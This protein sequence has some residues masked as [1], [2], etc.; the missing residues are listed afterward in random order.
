MR[1]HWKRFLLMFGLS[2]LAAAAMVTVSLGRYA[3]EDFSL[4]DLTPIYF[5]LAIF[6][7]PLTAFVALPALLLLRPRLRSMRSVMLYPLASAL[8]V[9]SVSAAASW[10]GAFV[11]ESMTVGEAVLF[12]GAFAV[13]G[14]TFGLAFIRLNGEAWARRRVTTFAYF[15]IAVCATA[16]TT[17]IL[18]FVE[19]ALLASADNG[20]V[21][22]AVTMSE[23]RSGHT[24]TLLPDGRVLLIGG[25]I[26]VRGDEVST[27]S[28]EIYDPRT[29]ATR[30]SGKLLTPRAG[31]TATL[32]PDGDVLVT[33]GGADQ[34]AL[35]GAELYRAKTG[36]FV[37]VG[38]MSAPRERHSATL[39][40]DGRVL[41]TGGTV[42]QPSDAAD[43]Y[44]PRTRTFTP[45]A[46]MRSR[47]A[48]HSSTLLKDG[49]VLIAG[50]AE[51]LESV[52]RS[53]EIYDPANNSF[54]EAGHLQ[55]PRYKHSAVS[56]ED[57]RVM[58]LG[59]SDERDWDGRRQSVEI[60]DPASG[61]SRLIAPMNRARFK[62]PNAV[63]IAVNGKVIVGGGGRRVE[64]YDH[65]ANRFVV[66]GG[67]VED[68]WFYATA[69]PLAGGRVFIAGG[70][71]DSLHPTNQTWVYRPPDG[72]R[73]SP[74]VH[75]NGAALIGRDKIF[76]QLFKLPEA[77]FGQL[78]GRNVMNK[79]RPVLESVL[80]GQNELSVGEDHLV[81]CRRIG[82]ALNLAAE[83]L[84]GGG[85]TGSVCAQEFFGL[86]AE[87]LQRR[88]RGQKNSDPQQRQQVG[89]ADSRQQVHYQSRQ[90]AVE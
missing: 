65:N 27:A 4:H 39:L 77:V 58:I 12:T 28:T 32:L 87:L 8:L 40:A 21:S 23:P 17:T 60:Y 54:T 62:F 42:A 46:R 1:V 72:A 64:V 49:R 68:E 43:I 50:G 63:A 84:C 73:R 44:V 48:A 45:A 59:G 80:A 51:S 81:G 14:L 74:V 82:Q 34:K 31:H 16:A 61:R 79:F 57:G 55:V 71:N 78:N 52:L 41:V 7:L 85:I 69:T 18:P 89:A 10:V 2:W 90:D 3:A 33:G 6:G 20:S 11:F 36:E 22:R 47:R 67:S 29:G 70:Y 76:R 38:L 30:P 83:A 26:S 53:V 75:A 24:A 15:V 5:T 25:M 37:P 9:A 86:F 35:I 19:E 56:L 66:G 13:M 88:T